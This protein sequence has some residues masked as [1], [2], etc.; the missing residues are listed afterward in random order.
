MAT[1]V[2]TDQVAANLFNWWDANRPA[3]VPALYPAQPQNASSLNEWIELRIAD[4]GP[5]PHRSGAPALARLSLL[6]HC[7]VKPQ[8][9]TSRIDVLV[10]AVSA[11]FSGQR[12][13]LLDYE[14]SGTPMIGLAS[15][16]EA[17][18]RHTT[19]THENRNEGPLQHAAVMIDGI[20]HPV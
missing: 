11:V 19:R 16:R 12:I 7:L 14:Q 4:L 20:V 8:S 5:L 3:G 13:P 10:D 17:E 18:V 9:D 2:T 15:L 1:I 6:A